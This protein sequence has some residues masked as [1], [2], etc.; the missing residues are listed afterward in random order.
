MCHALRCNLCPGTGV[1]HVYSL[2]ISRKVSKSHLGARQCAH[3]KMTSRNDSDLKLIRGSSPCKNP[4]SPRVIHKADEIS[5]TGHEDIQTPDT[6]YT[7]NN[8][9]R[10]GTHR[11]DAETRGQD[12]RQPPCPRIHADIAGCL[13]QLPTSDKGCLQGQGNA[14]RFL[15]FR[16]LELL[17][18]VSMAQCTGG[19]H[20]DSG[21]SGYRYSHARV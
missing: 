15:D 14:R 21:L 17:S 16:L 3:Q 8:P 1:T 13:D 9:H 11:H 5:N 6:P 18:L 19:A 12:S 4:A 10:D 2:Y 20:A 7:R